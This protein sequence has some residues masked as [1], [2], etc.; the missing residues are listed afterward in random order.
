MI[1]RLLRILGL[2]LAVLVVATTVGPYIVPLPAQPDLPPP[3]VARDLGLDG[4]FIDVDG[5]TTFIQEAGPTDGRAVFLIHGFGGSTF[6]WRLTLPALAEAGYHAVAIDLRNFGLSDKAWSAD[7]SHAAQARFVRAAMDQLGIARASLVGHSM[8]ANVAVHLAMASPE[9][10]TSLVLVDGATGD[11]RSGEFGGPLAGAAPLLLELPP[12]RRLAQHVIRRVVTPGRLAEIL[13]SAYLDPGT[14][15]PETRAGYLAQT[16]TPDWDLALL[17]VIRDR[18]E[19]PLPRPLTALDIP[20]I[21]IWGAGDP[22]IPLASGEAIRDAIPG[23]AWA[24]IRG[25]GHLPFEEQPDAFM[26]ELLR[27]LEAHS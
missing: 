20:A 27:F 21:V 8:G 2:L 26:A 7:T 17:A 3:E 5:T 1:R 16:R 9:R 13:G 15:T 23:A 12:L 22:W 18:N 24:V 11:G 10:V 4:R 19:R 25:A 6:S 14:V